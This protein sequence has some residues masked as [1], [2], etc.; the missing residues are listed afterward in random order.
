MLHEKVQADILGEEV[1]IGHR[2]VILAEG[3]WVDLYLD[4]PLVCVV[5]LR[6]EKPGHRKSLLHDVFGIF[7]WSLEEG[8]EVFEVGVCLIVGSL[9]FIDGVTLPDA[10][11]EESI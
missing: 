2:L 8:F 3:T 6:D 1:T 7:H 10:N 5:G 11:I 9:P 4:L